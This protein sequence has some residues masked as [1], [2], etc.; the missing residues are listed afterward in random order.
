MAKRNERVVYGIP[1][2]D[3]HD[4]EDKEIA[5]KINEYRARSV[6]SFTEFLTN[7]PGSEKFKTFL[8]VGPGDTADMDLFRKTNPNYENVHGIDLYLDDSDYTEDLIKGDWYEMAN[9]NLL[10]IPEGESVNAMYINHSLEHAANIYALM[11]Q[12]SRLQNKG[13]ALFI[14]VP[15]GNSE[16]GYAITS[17]TTHF[18][19]ITKG[20]LATTLQ[21][22]GYQVQ[23]EDKEFREGAP[24]LWSHAIKQYDG[25]GE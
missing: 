5:A 15:E 12:V 4:Y 19:V 9:E 14:A 17:S 13:D 23:V 20:F 10:A 6:K 18:S 1:C 7:V 3:R 21:R 8:D 24:E 2:I 16:F 11:E 22:F 25:F